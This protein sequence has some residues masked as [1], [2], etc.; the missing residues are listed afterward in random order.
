[1]FNRHPPTPTVLRPV[2]LSLHLGQPRTHH[3]LNSGSF[4][5]THPNHHRTIITISTAFWDACYRRTLQPARRYLTLAT[6]DTGFGRKTW[7]P[8]R[9]AF[10][11]PT[12]SDPLGRGRSGAN[13]CHEPLPR[14]PSPPHLTCGRGARALRPPYLSRTTEAPVRGGRDRRLA[15]LPGSTP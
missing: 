9:V 7:R 11:S 12:H 8:D 5:Q 6:H 4:L 1:M 13:D 3:G 15:A 14:C 10:A 2:E